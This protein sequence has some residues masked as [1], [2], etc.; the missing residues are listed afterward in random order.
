MKN[1]IYAVVIAACILVAVLVFVKTRGGGSVGHRSLS[2]TEQVW[3]K[4]LS[5]ANPMR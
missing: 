3:M 2:D 4:C 1:L 5:A